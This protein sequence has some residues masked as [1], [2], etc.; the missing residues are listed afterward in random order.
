M[1]MAQAARVQRTLN[2]EHL[3]PLLM[4]L[5]GRGGDITKIRRKPGETETCTSLI[6]LFWKVY[7]IKCTLV[8]SSYQGSVSSVMKCTD[9]CPE[10]KVQ[11]RL[12]CLCRAPLHQLELRNVGFTRGHG[13]GQSMIRI[14]GFFTEHGRVFNYSIWN[15]LITVFIALVEIPKQLVLL[16]VTI[17][18]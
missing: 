14:R 6:S 10:L 17:F 11:S 2:R 15:C 12:Q 7:L 8:M 4:C 1:F 18:R 16:P 13:V 5:P 3:Q 9:P